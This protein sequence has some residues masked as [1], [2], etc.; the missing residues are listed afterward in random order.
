MFGAY[1]AFCSQ[2]YN[3]PDDGPCYNCNSY[4]HKQSHCKKQ[5][6]CGICSEKYQIRDCTN[7]N[8]PKYPACMGPH[9]IF[10]RRC[11]RHPRH[12]EK[13]AGREEPVGPHT[14]PELHPR[15]IA[16]PSRPRTNPEPY[17][18]STAR[19]TRTGANRTQAHPPLIIARSPI[20]RRRSLESI[21]VDMGSLNS[22]QF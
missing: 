19:P 9:P 13:R 12:I 3:A 17:P 10:N 18:W 22:T 2:Y 1:E 5:T 16:G 14:D 6:K 7:R 21:D 20:H 15:P 8:K 11:I 4:G